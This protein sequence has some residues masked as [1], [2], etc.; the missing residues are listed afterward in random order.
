MKGYWK[1]PEA[2][3]EVL[4]DGWLLTGDIGHED[5]DGFVYVTDRKKDMIIYKGYNVY[6][7]D[8]EEVIFKHPAVQQ[9]A[10]LGKS[11]FRTGEFP[12]AIIELKRGA[13]ATKEEIL[14]H[15]NSQVAHYKKV[16]EVI[17]VDTIPV[18]FAGKVLKKDLKG[19][20]T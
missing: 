19:L 17:F 3:E 10:V 2:T 8:I 20:V 13:Q 15:T 12:V 5:E 7:R 11:D 1:N 18:S 16:R 14:E 9:C 4:K 6:P